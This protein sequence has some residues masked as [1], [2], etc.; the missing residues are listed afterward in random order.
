MSKVFLDTIGCRLNQAEIER[1]AR[2]FRQAGYEIV[3]SAAQADLVVVNSCT[4]TAAAASDSR[5]AIR[6]AH[7]LGAREIIATGCWATL[8][9]GNA[10]ALPGV[11]RVVSNAHKDTLVAKLL[12]L[13][14]ET[15]D[16]ELIARTPLPGLHTRTRA[17]IKVQDGCDQACTYCITTLA[18]GA[19]ASVPMAEIL[20]DVQAALAGSTHEAVLTGVHLGAW[21]FDLHPPQRLAELVRM[22]LEKVSIPRLRLSSLEPWDLDPAFFSLWEDTR[23]CPHLHLPL[24]SGSTSVL[25]RMGR[26]TSPEDFTILVETARRLIPGV[27]ITTDLMTGF[28][29]ETREE[30]EESLAFVKGMSFSG[31]HVFTFSPRPGTAAARMA[32]RVPPALAR[33]RS[34]VL[35]AALERSAIEYRQG[36]MG[37]TLPVLWES[38]TKLNDQG[39]QMEGWSPNYLRVAA[40]SPVPRW[41]EI[42]QVRLTALTR[43]GV[44]GEIVG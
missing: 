13:P 1:L 20:R 4:V 29:G 5:A 37:S 41:N 22:L 35:R 19:S 2:Q 27:A 15:F 8:E 38:T 28:P 14:E 11:S 7:R 24:Q 17:F 18:R 12:G 21:G 6:R 16:L 26:K 9:P 42:S 43:D 3:A 34:T 30:F 33:E 40:L 44:A 39:W 10:A 31:G 36:W 25:K 23:L 32:D